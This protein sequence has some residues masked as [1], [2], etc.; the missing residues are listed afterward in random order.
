MIQAHL[1]LLRCALKNA[2]LAKLRRIRQPKY[3]VAL[4]VGLLYFAFLFSGNLWQNGRASHSPMPLAAEGAWAEWLA[5]VLG[6]IYLLFI[7]A[8]RTVDPGLFFKPAEVQY[9]FPAPLTR[10]QILHYYLLRAQPGIVLSVCFLTLFG[11]AQG[12]FERPLFA[13]IAVFLL[14]ETIFL[15][16]TAASLVRASLFQHGA[17]GLRRNRMPLLV[18]VVIVILFAANGAGLQVSKITSSE[19]L[20]AFCRRT[21]DAPLIY[22]LTYPIR[23][24][25]RLMTSGDAAAFL[26][27]LA[28]VLGVIALHYVWVVRSNVAFE[29]ASQERS[30]R[31][32]AQIEQLKKRGLRASLGKETNV[33]RQPFRMRASGPALLALF[34]KNLI[35]TTRLPAL[36]LLGIL[37]LAAAATAVLP[38]DVRLFCS[39]VATVVGA[40][41]L[42]MGPRLFSSDLRQDLPN[43]DILKTLPLS[44]RQVVVGEIL[45][46]LAMLVAVELVVVA[47]ALAGFGSWAETEGAPPFV[48]LGWI[49]AVA[50]VY[51]AYAALW[52]LLENAMVLYLPEWVPQ[53][54]RHKQGIEMIGASLF[55]FFLVF[56]S[57]S[58]LLLPALLVGGAGVT[59][60]LLIGP[61]YLP[62]A[63]PILG[64]LVAAVLAAEC[65]VLLHFV[66]RR[67]E[68]FDF[69]TE[70]T[71]RGE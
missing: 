37:V 68:A 67:Y 34:W 53:R 13:T 39:V 6:L 47:A 19:A 49:A 44:G 3:A 22:Y 2:V 30:S 52:L 59:V 70:V 41:L 36:P 28:P 29:E 61:Q 26:A 69:S 43:L 10:R 17:A 16:Q 65:A 7:W 57:L 51:P 66:G 42:L 46:P 14:I 33:R 27:N 1:F 38:L 25:G 32:A 24:Y 20:A 58:G 31:T 55:Y 40:L 54:S 71:A 50:V 63:L 12:R 21:L 4:V 35:A 5:V 23:V 15:H 45:G 11:V 62:A 8:F 48:I 60:V 18:F 9:L 64:V 56:L